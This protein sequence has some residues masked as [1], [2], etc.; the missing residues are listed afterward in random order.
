M[1]ND[2][3]TY[4]YVLKHLGKD[5]CGAD[6]IYSKNMPAPCDVVESKNLIMADG[7]RIPYGSRQERCLSCG[8]YFEMKTEYF[9]KREIQTWIVFDSSVL[10]NTK[11]NY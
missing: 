4:P 7:E 1:K 10:G 2:I 8:Q 3:N 6:Y 11:D 9:S 5:G